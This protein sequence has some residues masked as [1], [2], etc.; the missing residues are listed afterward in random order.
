GFA[1]VAAEV[2][3]LSQHARQFSERLRT[4][5]EALKTTTAAVR[6]VVG[7]VAATD[8]NISLDAKGRVDAMMVDINKVNER[9]A[10]SL[11]AISTVMQQLHTDV[12]VAVRALQFEDIISQLL[13]YTETPLGTLRCLGT[14][15]AEAA[16]TN[17]STPLLALATTMAHRREEGQT[18]A[19]KPVA[20]TSMHAGDVELF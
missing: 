9:V 4:Q 12:G 7:G 11:Q 6:K 2:R 10:Q 20:Q 16:E 13:H 8:L 3:R 18:E 5:I 17:D 19:H 1:V 14:A 15:L